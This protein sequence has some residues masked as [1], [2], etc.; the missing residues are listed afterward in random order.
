MAQAT[1]ILSG[2]M[3]QVEA[4]ENMLFFSSG[5]DIKVSGEKDRSLLLAQ[6][7]VSVQTILL[8][9]VMGWQERLGY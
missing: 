9:V 5:W 3:A 4:S 7:L 6:D 8:P 1:L 2:V